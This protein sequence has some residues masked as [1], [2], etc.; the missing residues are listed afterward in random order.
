MNL[1][2]S[3]ANPLDPCTIVSLQALDECLT[4]VARRLATCLQPLDVTLRDTSHYQVFQSA[5]RGPMICSSGDSLKQ[6][7]AIP[8]TLPDPLSGAA[9]QRMDR[10]ATGLRRWNLPS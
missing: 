1:C 7:T 2:Q 10:S 5:T 3:C 8:Q 4:P 6:D 9:W